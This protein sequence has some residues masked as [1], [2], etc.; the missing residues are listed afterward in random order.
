[1]KRL[2]AVIFSVLIL[3]APYSLSIAAGGKLY[4]ASNLWYE[5]DRA[6]K[7]KPIPS[8]NYKKGIIIPAG[9]QVKDVTVTEGRRGSM[10]IDFVISKGGKKYAIHY[11]PKYHTGI[12]VEV[13]KKRLFTP[14]SFEALTKGFTKSEMKGVK[15]GKVTAGMRKKAVLVTYGYAPEHRTESIKSNVW[16]YWLDRFRTRKV[17]FNDKGVVVSE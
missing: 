1:M 4:R 3:T 9:T 16:L 12:D 14:K 11:Q 13:Y 15:N 7:I 6:G 17:A 5:Y 2:F 8:I 10:V